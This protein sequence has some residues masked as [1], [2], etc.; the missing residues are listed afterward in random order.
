MTIINNKKK[1]RIGLVT[2]WFPCGAGYVSKQYKEILEQKY[3]VFIYARGGVRQKNN[4]DWDG[5]HV[6]WA[7]NHSEVTGVYWNHFI[8]WVRKN[9]IKIL[10]FN[11]Q[12]YWPVVFKS[13]E[14]GLTV[15]AYVDYYTQ[16]TVPFF[17]VFDFLICNTKRHYSVFQWHD[18]CHYIPWGVSK[19][20]WP[21]RATETFSE[22]Q[23]VISAGWDGAYARHSEWMDRRG[24]GTVL[25]AFENIKG[26][27]RLS[28]YSQVTLND[29]P[30]HWRE[31]IKNNDR[32]NFHFGTFEP[33]PYHKNSV[34]VYPSRLDG[35]GLTVPEALCA[36]LPVIATDCAPMNEFVIDGY[37]GFL[38]NVEKSISRPDGY[39]WPE[40][41]FSH[42]D[43]TVLMQKYVDDSALLDKHKSGCIEYSEN[44]LS[45]HKN[46]SGIIQIFSCSAKKKESVPPNLKAHIK[47]YQKYKPHGPVI[48][49]KKTIRYYLGLVESLWFKW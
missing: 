17:E 49:L 10:F 39:Y 30:M 31:I 9:N 21:Q 23:F 1:Q 20:H 13:K 47:K 43:L 5:D 12:R 24:T 36:G 25:K 4:P 14:Y 18:N 8:A 6:T 41:I 11:E 3:E 7:P 40:S 2:T 32:I 38:I 16:D 42:S 37:N 15:G 29:C 45:W 22:V 19:K 26:D 46:S 35:I 27:C 28:I 33:F 48:F 44:N 34:Y